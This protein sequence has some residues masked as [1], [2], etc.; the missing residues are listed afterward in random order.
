MANQPG[1]NR[2][3]A[4]YGEVKGRTN[5]YLL[6]LGRQS[7]MGAGVLGRFDGVAGSYGNAQDLRVN[8]VT[9]ALVDYSK[10]AKPRFYGASVD[11]GA[12]TLYGI[13]QTLEGMQDRRAIGQ[14]SAISTIR[15][16]HM[17]W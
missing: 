9:G 10:G 13:N 11:K 16:R 2:V 8:A 4:A 7:S 5:D 1:Q 12:F 15:N 14:K 6:R 3:N 17:D